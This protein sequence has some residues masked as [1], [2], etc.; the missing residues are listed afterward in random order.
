MFYQSSIKHHAVEPVAENTPHRRL[1]N[2]NY[3]TSNELPPLKGIGTERRV[4]E[5]DQLVAIQ[6]LSAE[7]PG[8]VMLVGF[9]CLQ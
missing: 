4:S 1:P 6:L 3:S 2:S 8:V 5:V 7:V 9:H